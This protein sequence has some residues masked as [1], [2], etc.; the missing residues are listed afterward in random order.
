[1]VDEKPI[2]SENSKVDEKDKEIENEKENKLEENKEQENEP[3]KEKEKENESKKDKEKEKEYHEEITD[4]KEIKALEE[5]KNSL[6]TITE[7]KD[8]LVLDPFVLLNNDFLIHFLR[9]RKLNI[10]KTTKMILDYYHWK[11]KINLDYIYSNYIFK[12]KYR[13]QLLF[14]HGFHKLTKDGHPIYF[15][16]AGLVQAE[17]LMKLGTSEEI[18][19]Y[20]VSI[21]E[22]IE[23]D[24]FKICSQI[25]GAYIHG[26]FNIIDFNGINSSFLNKKLISYVRD[27]LKV[28][29]D[30]Y[31]ECLGKCYILNANLLFRTFYS[32]VKI[33]LDSKTKEKIKVF[34]N[35]Y[36]QALLEEI[37]S[38]NL[39]TFFGGSCECPEGC[40]FSNAGPWKKPEDVEEDIP[41]DILKRR[42]E[43]IDIMISNFK[44]I[45]TNS[46][47]KNKTNSKEG[48]KLDEL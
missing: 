45:P 10:K 24:Y 1:M 35:N 22:K 36:K 34:G 7:K 12:E 43:I 47:E 19:K 32:A 38:D 8:R 30:Y 15:Q 18:A 14:P 41:E 11:A 44:K 28:E 42:K 20:S 23:R 26:V 9:A 13:F 33:F 31:P 27:N 5:I 37:D 17:E 48:V 40:L 2:E 4:P 25:K 3:E 29:Q 6:A 16:I 21:N 39:P 46:D